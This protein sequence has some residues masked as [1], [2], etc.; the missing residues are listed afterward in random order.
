MLNHIHAREHVGNNDVIRVESNLAC[1]VILLDDHNY[2]LYKND[3]SYR[4]TGGFYRE[5]PTI[6]VPPYPGFWNI[7]VDLGGRS[8]RLECRFTTITLPIG[9]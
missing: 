5:F 4:Y 1:N 6:V 7:V 2:S 9:T 8:G 3:Q